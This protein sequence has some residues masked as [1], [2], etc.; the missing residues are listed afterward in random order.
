M[1]SFI[2]RRFR[3]ND[4]GSGWIR[5]FSITQMFRLTI[6]EACKFAVLAQL[7]MNPIP[8][9]IL[10]SIGCMVN[11]LMPSLV[12][13]RQ[14][15]SLLGWQWALPLAFYWVFSLSWIS[16]WGLISATRSGWLTREIVTTPDPR[17]Q[18]EVH[19]HHRT[20]KTLPKAA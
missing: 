14:Y 5:L 8:T 12:Y 18:V 6:G 9:M 16:F 15:H 13:Q 2:T 7:L 17:A 19:K 4:S 20:R 3:P 10:I 11:A 1:F